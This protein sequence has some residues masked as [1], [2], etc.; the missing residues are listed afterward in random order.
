M[1]V[2]LFCLPC[3]MTTIISPVYSMVQNISTYDFMSSQILFWY[4]SNA[5]S[6]LVNL[7]SNILGQ[8]IGLECVTDTWRNG[9]YLSRRR[10]YENRWFIIMFY[11]L[12]FATLSCQLMMIPS[13]H[14][15]ISSTSSILTSMGYLRSL[16]HRVSENNL[17]WIFWGRFLNDHYNRMTW[18]L[19]GNR[20]IS[21]W[22]PFVN[23]F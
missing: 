14:Y 11:W 5:Y 8:I 19:S 23:T 20:G 2:Q 4:T 10:Y 18:H 13:L 15:T 7:G 17:L 21:W 9:N 16:I 1:P 6:I 22:H 12:R 3:D